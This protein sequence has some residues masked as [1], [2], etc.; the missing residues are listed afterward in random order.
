MESSPAT[1][2]AGR[3]SARSHN[4]FG[5]RGASTAGTAMAKV[6]VPE[7]GFRSSPRQITRP[8]KVERDGHMLTVELFVAS[9]ES[10]DIVYDFGDLDGG[11]GCMIPSRDAPHMDTVRLFDGEAPVRVDG[12]GRSGLNVR[13]GKLVRRLT[14][15]PLPQHLRRLEVQIVGRDVGEWRAPIELVPLDGRGAASADA[16]ATHAGITI[17]VTSVAFGENDTAMELELSGT[18][19]VVP[20]W[21]GGLGGMRDATTALSIRDGAGSTYQERF[22]NDARDQIESPRPGLAVALFPPMPA[23]AH[24]LTVEVPYIVATDRDARLDVALPVSEPRSL[25]FGPYPVVIRQSGVAD[26]NAPWHRGSALALDL[27]LGDWSNDR[28]VI[29]PGTPRLDGQMTGMGYGRGMYAPSPKPVEHLEL[30]AADPL[31]ARMLTFEGATVHVRGP[32]RIP[33]AR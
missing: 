11:P 32:W 27:D 2:A 1:A 33:L 12:A 22:R 9:D 31:A 29:M 14:L 15:G 30:A 23:D 20:E 21:V 24:D 18:G 7:V 25:L 17:A 6:Y 5:R 28:R 19:G 4:P 26:T 3:S 16:S 10:T 13:P 8:V